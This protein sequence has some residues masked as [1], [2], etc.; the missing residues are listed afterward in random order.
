MFGEFRPRRL[1]EALKE[2]DHYRTSGERE[3]GVP[4]AEEGGGGLSDEFWRRYLDMSP[5][6]PFLPRLRNPLWTEKKNL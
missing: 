3:G 2:S 4:K 5:T 6:S 1:A